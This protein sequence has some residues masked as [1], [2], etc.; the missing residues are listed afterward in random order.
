VNL[1]FTHAFNSMTPIEKWCGKNPSVGHLRNFECISWAHIS[2]ACRKE[3]DA[4]S[5]VCIM[6]GY[7]E[8]SKSYQLFSP[9]KII[10]RRNVIFHENSLGLK[11]LNSS[12]SLLNNDLFDIVPSFGST[13][14]LLG[15]STIAETSLSKSTGSHYTLTWLALSINLLKGLT[16]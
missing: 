8:E 10:I 14:P 3:L 7:S 13:A 15:A 6:T 5:H 2:N 9:V 4:K 11:L 12:S 16:M 1:V